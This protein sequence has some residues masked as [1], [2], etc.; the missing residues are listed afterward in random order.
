MPDPRDLHLGGGVL[1]GYGDGRSDAFDEYGRR[2][3]HADYKKNDPS[4]EECTLYRFKGEFARLFGPKRRGQSEHLG[5]RQR[6]V[7]SEDFHQYHLD[8]EKKY[9]PAGLRPRRSVRT[10]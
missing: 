7:D 4:G 8:L 6:E 5:G 3:W 1:I 2:P 10:R 9:R